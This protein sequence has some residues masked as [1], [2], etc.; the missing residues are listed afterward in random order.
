MQSNISA[1]VG[2]FILP[3]SFKRLRDRLTSSLCSGSR[4]F[5]SSS[6]SNS[7]MHARNALLLL[8]LSLLIGWLPS[9]QT[10]LS[11]SDELEPD[12]PSTRG[13]RVANKT[14]I[15]KASLFA[16]FVV[17]L[18]T[19]GNLPAMRKHSIVS[20]QRNSE[21]AELRSTNR[22]ESWKEPFH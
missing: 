18:K 15:S 12:H 13:V 9:C 16:V 4:S 2:F 7:V 19:A 22:S 14:C 17:P 8:I 1:F 6:A 21:L 11:D 10:T 5:L 20:C 3:S